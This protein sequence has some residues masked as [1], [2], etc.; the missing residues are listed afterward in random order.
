MKKIILLSLLFGVGL[1]AKV[2]FALDES[3][4]T[5]NTSESLLL[6]TQES[7]RTATSQSSVRA[8]KALGTND[9]RLKVWASN[10]ELRMASF[11]PAASSTYTEVSDVE[12]DGSTYTVSN[13][14]S[15]GTKPNMN[16]FALATA[17][18][19]VMIRIV[20]NPDLFD[21]A[22]LRVFDSRGSTNALTGN[23]TSGA[24]LLFD[25]IYRSSQTQWSVGAGNSVNNSF[26]FVVASGGVILADRG[27]YW[28]WRD[29]TKLTR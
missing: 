22:R 7:S 15:F 21:G 10:Y 6:A 26:D 14:S 27:G 20:P 23:N 11:V 9:G 17:S 28:V 18:E 29:K 8:R 25:G 2:A 12:Y 24:V 19:P 13:S 5:I 1:T 3:P 4:I 16:L